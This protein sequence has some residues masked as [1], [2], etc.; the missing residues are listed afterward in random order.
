M[1]CDCVQTIAS[2]SDGSGRGITDSGS[3]TGPAVG[4]ERHLIQAGSVVEYQLQRK[5]RILGHQLAADDG[6]CDSERAAGRNGVLR[7]VGGETTSTLVARL[8]SQ[9]SG[10]RDNPF[11]QKRQVERYRCGASGPDRPVAC[12]SRGPIGHADSSRRS[13]L[14]GDQDRDRDSIA[15][16]DVF[17]Q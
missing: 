12:D 1:G 16:V 13:G 6:A 3:I 5:R 15:E 9:V 2:H 10:R 11:L 14:A 8:V 17:R 4:R 7:R